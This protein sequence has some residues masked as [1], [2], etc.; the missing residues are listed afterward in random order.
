VFWESI[1]L[2]SGQGN[3]YAWLLDP[4]DFWGK[5]MKI[6][7]VCAA[8]L[9][10]FSWINYAETIVVKHSD[11]CLDVNHN[12]IENGARIIQYT[13]HYQANQ[14]FNFRDLGNGFYQI[15]AEN[16][17]KCLDVSSNSVSDKA[18]VIQYSCHSGNNQQ[19]ELIDLGNGY[20]AIR[21]RH[22][23]KCLDISEASQS[24]GA[25]L[26]QYRCHYAPNQQFQ[27]N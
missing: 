16:S 4:G 5:N 19:F 6:H 12:S 24:N 20:Q 17:G 3:K 2:I 27:I 8:F 11:K 7:F 1:A 25:G 21:A 15:V 22:S 9:M 13:C 26:I 23:S 14:Q 18:P 10:S